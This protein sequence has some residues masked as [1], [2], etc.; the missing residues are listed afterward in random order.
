MLLQNAVQGQWWRRYRA[1]EL[2]LHCGAPGKCSNWSFRAWDKCLQVFG[3]FDASE[4]NLDQVT[5][6]SSLRLE[7]NSLKTVPPKGG[8]SCPLLGLEKTQWAI[9]LVKDTATEHSPLGLGQ[10]N[11]FCSQVCG[12]ITIVT[13]RFWYRFTVPQPSVGHRLTSLSENTHLIFK[14]SMDVYNLWYYAE[15]LAGEKKF[16]LENIFLLFEWL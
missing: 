13:S 11:I 9:L 1:C 10:E 2:T 5:V 3:V 4:I 6:Q 8:C 14:S 16:F 7:V 12:F 15:I